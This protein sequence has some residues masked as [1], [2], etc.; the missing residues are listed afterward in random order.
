MGAYVSQ[1]SDQEENYK[2]SLLI[3]LRKSQ[4]ATPPVSSLTSPK[5]VQAST[6]VCLSSKMIV[7]SCLLLAL[8]TLVSSL[9]ADVDDQL[10]ASGM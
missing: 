6:M 3:P 7:A 8:V 9:S 10:Q 5:F 2:N 4:F 1:A